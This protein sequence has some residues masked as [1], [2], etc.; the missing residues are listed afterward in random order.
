M[1]TMYIKVKESTIPLLN[2]YL[3]IICKSLGNKETLK[4][5]NE[6]NS[7][8]EK[9]IMSIYFFQKKTLFYDL[10]LLRS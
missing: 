5:V 1:I 6:T 3:L 10:F 8:M 2:T 9:K 4:N 7:L